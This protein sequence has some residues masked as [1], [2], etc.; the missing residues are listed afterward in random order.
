MRKRAAAAWLLTAAMTVTVCSPAVVQAEGV[1]SVDNTL[2]AE[3]DFNTPAV[4]GAITGTGAPWSA[5]RGNMP[6]QRNTCAGPGRLTMPDGRCWSTITNGWQAE[7]G[8]PFWIRR[9][10]RP[11]VPPSFPAAR[12]PFRNACGHAEG[13]RA[14]AERPGGR[15][16]YKREPMRLLRPGPALLRPGPAQQLRPGPER[17]KRAG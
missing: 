17:Q 15:T 3:L 4:D 11:R 7:N 13:R 5:G 14:K 16:A 9:A 8:T 10:S 6:R 2:I 12:L 1:D